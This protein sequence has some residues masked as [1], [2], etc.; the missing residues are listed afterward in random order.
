M[1]TR[2]PGILVI[3]HPEDRLSN[4]I[5]TI[6]QTQG[7]R[8][9]QIVPGALGSKQISLQGDLL[10]IDGD[11]VKGILFRVPPQSAFSDDFAINDQSFCDA[12]IR[13]VLL[14]ALN[15]ESMLAINKYDA[16]TWFEGIGWPTWR[17][18]L[19]AAGIPVTEF[20]FGDSDLNGRHV[21]Y[22]YASLE[23]K[24]APGHHSRKIL[25]SALTEGTP[26]QTSLIIGGEILTGKQSPSML[27]TAEF[28]T[29]SGA[30]LAE[31]ATDMD[32]RVVTIN[33]LPLISDVEV[34]TIV[35]LRISEMFHAHLHRG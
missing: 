10:C 27:A 33:T 25:G 9:L 34:N 35:S 23:A 24:L 12:E 5:V 21:W 16:T 22:P 26:L 11:P 32:D 14:A 15:L 29:N 3:N 7:I 28:L 30:C 1:F 18:K 31:V 6:L 4:S 17:R 20:Q 2:E 13:A 19:I 8:V